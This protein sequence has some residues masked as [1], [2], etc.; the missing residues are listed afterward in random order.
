MPS[1]WVAFLDESG[2]DGMDFAQ[3]GVSEHYVMAAVAVRT[4]ELAQAELVFR[5]AKADLFAKQPEMKSDYVGNNDRRRLS[6]I[7]SLA[8]ASFD[9]HLRVTH[10]RL[11]EGRGFRHPRSFVKY[12]LGDLVSEL[13]E[14]YGDPE[15]QCDQIKTPSF[16]RDVRQYLYSHYPRTLMCQ[17]NFHFVNSKD[18]VCVQAADVIAGAGRRCCQ[19]SPQS[20]RQDQLLQ[21][22]SKHLTKGSFS[23]F[24]RSTISGPAPALTDALRSH[25]PELEMKAVSDAEA[26]VSAHIGGSDPRRAAEVGCVQEL[27]KHNTLQPSSE[28]LS[29]ARLLAVCEHILGEGVNERR[30]RSFVGRLRDDGLLIASRGKPGGYKLP[31]GI[32]DVIEFLKTQNN[33]IKPMMRRV[34]KARNAIW[35]LVGQ[36]ILL[37]GDFGNLLSLLPAV[38]TPAEEI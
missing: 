1:K 30:L 9:L 12:L 34:Q 27:L 17:W 14:R 33:Q 6:V 38:G 7:A 18:C 29:T 2:N 11:L 8:K 10:K 16:Q 19:R 21:L 4:C 35:A 23:R 13:L 20:P 25:D 22:V 5:E 36:D 28:W 15:I 3:Q 26:Y 37:A 31:T 24:P 32:S